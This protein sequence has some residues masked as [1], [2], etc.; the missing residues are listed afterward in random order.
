MFLGTG[1]L[2]DTFF[3]QSPMNSPIADDIT[4][5]GLATTRVDF[6]EP[7]KKARDEGG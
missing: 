2:H 3:S 7:T 4:D 5:V 6:A 1:I